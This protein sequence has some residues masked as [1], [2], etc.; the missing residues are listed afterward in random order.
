MN[1]SDEI[2]SF[3]QEYAKKKVDDITEDTTLPSDLG[4][5]SLTFVRMVNDAEKKFNVTIDDNKLISV[6]TVRDF[7]RLIEQ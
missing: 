4:I 2:I 7:V 1:L 3:I 6:R 5:D